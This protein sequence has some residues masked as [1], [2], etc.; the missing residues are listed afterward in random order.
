MEKRRAARAFNDALTDRSGLDGRTEKR[1]QRLLD[2]LRQGKRRSTGHELKPVEVLLH[3]QE[4]LSLDEP[5]QSLKKACPPP[6]PAPETPQ[7][8]ELVR[9]LH[10]AYE[11]RPE[12]YRFVG[13]A[14]EVLRTAGVL[15]EKPKR[16]PHRG[17][18]G[19]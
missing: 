9:R 10:R 14:D 18:K 12:T 5:L 2:E 13:V 17:D 7:L 11:F 16:G 8:V 15:R 6:K 19:R 4:L 1:R 3:V